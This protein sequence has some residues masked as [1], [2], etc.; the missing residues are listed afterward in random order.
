MDSWSFCSN[1]LLE[2]AQKRIFSFQIKKRFLISVAKTAYTAR[3][4][5]SPDKFLRKRIEVGSMGV[6]KEI[7]FELLSTGQ[8]E[9]SGQ[10]YIFSTETVLSA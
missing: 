8:R 7:D 10:G 3:A 1:F 5:S 2:I 9:A 4:L 6:I